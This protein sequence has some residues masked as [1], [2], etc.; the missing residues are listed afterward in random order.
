MNA[1]IVLSV[2]AEGAHQRCSQEGQGVCLQLLRPSVQQEVPSQ[3]A[4]RVCTSRS[5]CVYYCILCVYG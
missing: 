3:Q 5:V 4:L 2:Q 1:S